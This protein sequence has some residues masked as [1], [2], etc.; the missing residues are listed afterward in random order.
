[1]LRSK[2]EEFYLECEKSWVFSTLMFVGGSCGVFTFAIRGV[3]FC[4][5]QTGI[6]VFM[7]MA[8]GEGDFAEAL[9]YFVPMAAYLLGTIVSE[10]VPRPVKRTHIIRWDTLLILIEM[11]AVILL[12]FV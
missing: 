9:Y 6:F 3:V 7:A 11:I 1:M 10:L 4:N 8:L 5:A 2:E 12:G